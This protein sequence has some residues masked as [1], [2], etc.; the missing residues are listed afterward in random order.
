MGVEDLLQGFPQLGEWGVPIFFGTGPR[1]PQNPLRTSRLAGFLKGVYPGRA[2]MDV[3][4]LQRSKI[5]DQKFGSSD[6]LFI[7]H[8]SL[9]IERRVVSS[10][11]CGEK[12]L[13]T[14]TNAINLSHKSLWY[15][16][17][18]VFAHW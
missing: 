1:L 11:R 18:H 10:R 15:L 12:I 7:D 9:V 5:T 13:W 4:N 6:D 14:V 2:G 16:Y 17:L 3:Y 8:Y